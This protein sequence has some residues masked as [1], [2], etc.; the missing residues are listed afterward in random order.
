MEYTFSGGYAKNPYIQLGLAPAVIPDQAVPLD[1]GHLRL[2]DREP[3]HHIPIVVDLVVDR[4]PASS[5]VPHQRAEGRVLGSRAGQHA[6]EPSAVLVEMGHVL[7]G[8]QLAI[9]HVEEV[10]PAGQLAEQF[11]GGAVR[12]VVGRIAALD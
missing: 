5:A 12:A 3:V 8:G 11:P 6:Q 1:A 4:S 2:V 10:T 9:G 7:G